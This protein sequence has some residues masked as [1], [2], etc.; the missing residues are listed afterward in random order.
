M[1]NKQ[2]HPSN[3]LRTALGL[4]LSTCVQMFDRKNSILLID[5]RDSSTTADHGLGQEIFSGEAYQPRC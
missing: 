4:R 1:L 2:P 3:G 5:K